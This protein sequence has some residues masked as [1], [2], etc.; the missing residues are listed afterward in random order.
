M[1]G[2]AGTLVYRH[3]LASAPVQNLPP[4]ALTT[5]GGALKVAEGMPSPTAQQLIGAAQSAFTDALQLTAL[6]GSALVLLASV[7]AA[8]M[9]RSSP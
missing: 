6:I 4:E 7:L 3:Q 8:R 1:F 9:L 2:S 5:L